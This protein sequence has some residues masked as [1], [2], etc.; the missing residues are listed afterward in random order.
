MSP[1]AHLHAEGLSKRFGALT[2]LQPLNLDIGAGSIFGYLGPNGAGKTTTLRLI[3]GLLRPSTGRVTVC[4]LDAWTERTQA[5]HHLGYLPGDFVADAK[6][7]ADEYLSFLQALRDIDCRKQVSRLAE[8]LHLDLDRPIGTL[9]HGNR[10]KVGI[11]QAMM[12]APD[13][14]V[15]DEPTSGLDPLAQREFLDLI[16]DAR[17]AG[18]T[19]LLSS[20][21]LSEVEAVADRVGFLR[22]GSLIDERTIADLRRNAPRRLDLTFA[23]VPPADQ[24]QHLPGVRHAETRGHIVRLVTEG[25]L[26]RAMAALAPY[27]IQNIVTHEADLEELFLSHYPKEDQDESTLADQDTA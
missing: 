18:G 12:S 9:S 6:A 13:V 26:S 22:E 10:Q 24:I 21:V 4:G 20:H 16:R 15:L 19:V 27:G 5:H 3:V 8:Q 7:T 1:A 25:D 23:A 14:L 2:A 17:D 11:I